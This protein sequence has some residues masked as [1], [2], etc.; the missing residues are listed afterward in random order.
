MP[1][2][3]S[4]FS[5]GLTP[6]LNTL[7]KGYAMS[8]IW[9]PA[10]GAD[11]DDIA[12]LAEDNFRSEVENEFEIDIP[13]LKYSITLAVV[14]QFYNP[15]STLLRILRDESGRIIAY[16]W[17]KS[18]DQAVWSR[19]RVLNIMM[20]HCDMSISPRTRIAILKDMLN[21]WEDYARYSQCSVISSSTIRGDQ[22]AF[23]R[24][25][26][27]QGYSVRGS[28]AYKRVKPQESS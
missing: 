16:T 1:L 11:V 2:S 7:S 8:L 15:A 9:T 25:H 26:E 3:C 20:A 12:R 22:S 14:H 10:V 13:H 24:L 21:M 23:L 4:L 27:R 5:T 19:D 17:A 28:V 6:G 18:G